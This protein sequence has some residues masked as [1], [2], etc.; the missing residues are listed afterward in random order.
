MQLYNLMHA[1]PDARLRQCAF[2]LLMRA[3]GQDPTLY[4]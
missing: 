1:T 3:T 2:M 4:R